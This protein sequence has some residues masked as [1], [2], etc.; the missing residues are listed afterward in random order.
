[1]AEEQKQDEA[2]QHAQSKPPTAAAKEQGHK[3][4]RGAQID[5]QIEKEE[6]QLLK[7]KHQI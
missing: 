4:S 5:E 6:E 3:P 2:D 7:D 1:M